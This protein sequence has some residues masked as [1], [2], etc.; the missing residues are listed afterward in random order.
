MQIAIEISDPDP[1]NTGWKVYQQ[2][3]CWAFK[4]LR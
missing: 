2:V 3:S 4:V 1:S